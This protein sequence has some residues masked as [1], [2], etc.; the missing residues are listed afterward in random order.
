MFWI[1]NG[2]IS[3]GKERQLAI[4]IKPSPKPKIGLIF[5]FEMAKIPKIRP[6]P[7]NIKVINKVIKIIDS[8][9]KKDIGK[10]TKQI[11]KNIMSGIDIRIKYERKIPSKR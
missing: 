9:V 2:K 6:K 10:K 3:N 4:K 5:S 7:L 8:T 11:I 1:N